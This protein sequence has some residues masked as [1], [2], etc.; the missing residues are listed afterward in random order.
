MVEFRGDLHFLS[1]FFPHPMRW[2]GL[3]F[4]TSEHA[5]QWAKTDSPWW[6]EKIRMAKSA[7]LAKWLAGPKSG[8]PKRPTWEKERVGVMEEVLKVKFANKELRQKLISTID[9]KPLLCEYNTWHDSFW[10]YCTCG[11]CPEGTNMLGKL[12]MNLRAEIC[13]AIENATFLPLE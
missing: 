8:C 2:K 10:G 5:Y 13:Q 4:P 6:K 3:S 7:S 1:N 9:S 12:L 11:N